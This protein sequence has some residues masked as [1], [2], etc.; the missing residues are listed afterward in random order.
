MA[1]HSKWANI[2]H[3]KGRQDKARAKLFSKLS[4]EV[5][6][7]AKMGGPD[8]D[9]NPRLRLAV[10]NAKGQSMP[11]DNIQRAID[12]ASGGDIDAFEDI[13]YEGF[14][15]G[16]VGIIVEV[17]TDNRNR[18]ASD[19]RA[20]F[21]KNGGNMG[22]TGSV[23]FMFEQVGEIRYD[24][25]VADEDVMFEAAIEAGAE[26]VT[27]EEGGEGEPGEHVVFCA[28]DD[29]GDVSKALEGAL[30]EAKSVNIIWKAGTLTPL[31]AE[32]AATLFKLLEALDDLDDVQ[33]VFDNSDISEEDL[34]AIE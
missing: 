18:A 9:M 21:T 12:K 4:K 6:I 13:R 14:G 16:G 17:S 15:P 28:R 20:A 27:Q 24:R 3:R 2:Q 19:T 33:T 22:E 29:L 10:N 31:D 23:S 32:K 8:P 26:D 7:A 30:G 5:T 11:K 1:G 34:A 25:T